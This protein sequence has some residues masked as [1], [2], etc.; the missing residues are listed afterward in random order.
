MQPKVMTQ[1]ISVSFSKNARRFVSI[2]TINHHPLNACVCPIFLLSSHDTD[3]SVL[4]SF[5]QS[6]VQFSAPN[7]L[8]SIKTNRNIL[9]LP[10]QNET[11]SLDPK[12]W[13]S[14]LW[15]SPLR[16]GESVIY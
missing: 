4:Q 12:K 3:S 2:I 6:I 1:R 16:G 11:K 8:N 7:A 9:Q 10:P 15:H 14:E 5:I 13:G